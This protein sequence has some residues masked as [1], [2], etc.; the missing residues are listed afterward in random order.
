MKAKKILAALISAVMAVQSIPMQVLARDIDESEIS[1][2]AV[3]Q[4][5]ESVE[6][7]V[8]KQITTEESELSEIQEEFRLVREIDENGIQYEYVVSEINRSESISYSLKNNNL[9]NREVIIEIYTAEDL[10]NI[11]LDMSGHYMLMND[12]DMRYYGNWIPLGNQ[13]D[14]FMGTL[15]GNGYSIKN[16]TI[17]GDEY[18]FGTESEMFTNIGLF[19]CSSYSKIEN[20]TLENLNVDVSVTNNVTVGGF[21]G[22]CYNG[23]Q[24]E[25]CYVSGKISAYSQD[26]CVYAGGIVGYFSAASSDGSAY[27][28]ECGNSA[29]II[30]KQEESN[31]AIEAGGIVGII[32]DYSTITSCWN[33]GN[34]SAYSNQKGDAGGIVGSVSGSGFIVDCCTNIGAVVGYSSAGGIAG[35]ISCN[36][37]VIPEELYGVIVEICNSSNKGNIESYKSSGG[38]IGIARAPK[39]YGFL[40][41]DSFNSGTITFRNSTCRYVYGG[42]ILGRAQYYGDS[43]YYISD[44]YNTGSIISKIRFDNNESGRSRLG[45]IFGSIDAIEYVMCMN[46]YNAGSITSTDPISSGGIAGRAVLASEN[47][48]EAVQLLRS[49]YFLAQENLPIVGYS[50]PY[51]AEQCSVLDSTQMEDSLSFAGFDFDTVWEIGVTVGYPYPTLLDNPVYSPDV[52]VW[53]KNV[54]YVVLEEVSPEELG[55]LYGENYPTDLWPDVTSGKLL[56]GTIVAGYNGESHCWENGMNNAAMAFDGD[57]ETFFDPFDANTQSWCGMLL[58]KPYHL[59]E[60][61]ILPRQEWEDRTAGAAIQ[62]SNDGYLWK[63]IVYITDVNL[64]PAGRNYHCI[65]PESNE[66]YIEKYANLGYENMDL[67]TYWAG[68]GAYRYYRYV[69]ME[70]IHGDVAEI[71]LYGVP[72]SAITTTWDT[73]DL[74]LTEGETYAFSGKIKSSSPLDTLHIAVVRADNTS[75]GIDY[76]YAE[77][78]SSTLFDLSTIPSMAAGALL[79]GLQISNNQGQL[80]FGSGSYLIRMWIAD[81][82]G[83]YLNGLTKRITVTDVSDTPV[84]EMLPITEIT[85][86]TAKLQ[87]QIVDARGG[88]IVDF[89][90][91]MYDT[92]TGGERH[93]QYRA[94]QTDPKYQIDPYYQ[95]AEYDPE[96]GIFTVILRDHN[97]NRTYYAEGFAVYYQGDTPVTGFTPERTGFTTAVAQVNITSPEAY[98]VLSSADVSVTGN[99]DCRV[100][101]ITFDNPILTVYDYQMTEVASA[102]VILNND[103]T[104][105]AEIDLTEHYAGTYSI[106]VSADASNDSSV[107]S[108]PVLFNIPGK[109]AVYTDPVDESKITATK[110][111]VT[112]RVPDTMGETLKYYGFRTYDEAGNPLGSYFVGHDDETHWT[113]SFDPAT[114]VITGTI[115]AE[116]DTTIYYEAFASYKIG[117]VQI[118][119]IAATRESFTTKCVDITLDKINSY[120]GQSYMLDE[121]AGKIK[122]SGHISDVAAGHTVD[123]PVVIIRD[124]KG[125]VVDSVEAVLTGKNF[126]VE[127]NMVGYAPGIYTITAEIVADSVVA[128]YS[129]RGVSGRTSTSNEKEVVVPTKASSIVFKTNLGGEVLDQNTVH[130]IAHWNWLV[131]DLEMDTKRSNVKRIEWVTSDSSGLRLSMWNKSNKSFDQDRPQ[132]CQFNASKIGSYTVTAN[133]YNYDGTVTSASLSVEVRA[134]AT[135]CF[136]D[137]L[138]QTP[139]AGVNVQIT[140]NGNKPY[141][142]SVSSD[143]AGQVMLYDVPYGKFTIKASAKGYNDLNIVRTFGDNSN[144][145]VFMY[146]DDHV[147]Y[148]AE[149]TAVYT[150]EGEAVTTHSNADILNTSASLDKGK[151]YTVSIDVVADASLDISCYQLIQKEKVIAESND[152]NSPIVLYSLDS[153]AA[154]TPSSIRVCYKNGSSKDEP[155]QLQFTKSS[156]DDLKDES[157]NASFSIGDGISVTLPDNIPLL[158]GQELKLDLGKLP[159]SF[160]IQK[161][162][163]YIVIGAEDLFKDVSDKHNDD[164]TLEMEQLGLDE[165]VTGAINDIKSAISQNKDDLK[166]AIKTL[167]KNLTNF[168]EKTL[169]ENKS[170]AFGAEIV[171]VVLGTFIYDFSTNKGELEVVLKMKAE[172]EKNFQFFPAGIPILVTIKFGG[173]MGVEISVKENEITGTDSADTFLEIAAKSFYPT[174]ELSFTAD[175]GLGIAEIASLTAQGTSTFDAQI[176]ASP[177]FH[178]GLGLNIRLMVLIWEHIANLAG[179]EWM[180]KNG[181]WYQKTLNTDWEH[182]GADSAA[183][184]SAQSVYS[185]PTSQYSLADRSYL[186]YTSDWYEYN[187]IATFA[188][189]GDR[190]YTTDTDTLMTYIYP[191]TQIQTV[192]TEDHKVMIWLTDDATRS[193]A[194]RTKLV[195]SVYDELT[196]KWTTPQ[197]VADDGTLDSYP[198]LATDGTSIWA[199]WVNMNTALTDDMG[200]DTG[201]LHSEICAAMFDPQTMS[202]RQVT[203]LTAN[204]VIDLNPKLAVSGDTVAAAWVSNDSGNLW[205]TSGTNTIYISMYENGS[206][207]DAQAVKVLN[208]AVPA[209]EI[210]FVDGT[211]SVAY[212][213]DQDNSF[214]TVDDIAV[215]ASVPGTSEEYLLAEG[216]LNSNLQFVTIEGKQ[217]LTWYSDGYVRS[218]STFGNE[219]RD[220]LNGAAVTGGYRIVSDVNGTVLLKTVP[221]DGYSELYVS[222]YDEDDDSWSNDIRLTY[223]N[224]A[225]INDFG[226]MV[227]ENGDITVIYTAEIDDMAQMCSG[228]IGFV[229]DISLDSVSH[230][231]SDAVPGKM[232]KLYADLTN[233]GI[234]DVESVIFRMKQNDEVLCETAVPLL[235][236]A[237]E[238]VSVEVPVTVPETSGITEYEVEVVL[239]DAEEIDLSNNTGTVEFGH[240]N[241]SLYVSDMYG[242]NSRLLTFE[243]INNGGY[244]TVPQIVIYKDN[245]EKTVIDTLDLDVLSGKSSS[246]VNY[247]LT[248]L[249]D[250]VYIELISDREEFYTGDNVV[251]Y[252]LES[253]SPEI[254]YGDANGDGSVTEADNALLKQYFAGYNVS[255]DTAAADVDNDRVLTRRDAMILARHLAGWEGYTLPYLGE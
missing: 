81:T 66:V 156:L 69:N 135:L 67:S 215:H 73:S 145:V 79:K 236:K 208:R 167:D 153:C 25:N 49:C 127:C 119:S 84:I 191:D 83:N 175:G 92:E 242:E 128:A 189:F 45:G 169:E 114:G 235:M 164:Y 131:V 82:A 5:M 91:N 110:A 28:N 51:T 149:M 238:T 54:S 255:V 88:I 162:K 68:D 214:E 171:P 120:D 252:S 115:P 158:G 204:D 249:E 13:I 2:E 17:M 93:A 39:N 247:T 179:I 250:S 198:Y 9:Q 117:D 41:I 152:G 125:N 7:V 77:Q 58:D 151:N 213:L 218:I 217:F 62:G 207:S 86:S 20:L 197:S 251:Y 168:K 76:H 232:T 174:V 186:D 194:N 142:A 190:D 89:G 248:D 21:F 19:A 161:N 227:E 36:S 95:T 241:L 16:L 192:Q 139:I 59:T 101:G 30:V 72:E 211:L 42:G 85:A 106:I 220:M 55:N 50:D 122:F 71:E 216:G 210:G 8:I 228:T 147:V 136:V 124:S 14:H 163:L 146:D 11:S 148:S 132:T 18:T 202:F 150:S 4:T 183:Y 63:N 165:K 253:D 222:V 107:V 187:D 32:M 144:P 141:S 138:T 31:F 29:E 229:K 234:A 15:D 231:T 203:A 180:Y 129:A 109:L 137:F 254:V 245:E 155:V 6:D 226:A 113:T 118:D 37:S 246:V 188:S 26:N 3:E 57:P 176:K 78:I 233:H 206:W 108:A 97:P 181:E 12:I 102:D 56:K 65:T 104:F 172:G 96:T 178:L 116:P 111:I 60:I 33:V 140:S 212:C 98:Q 243:V 48:S 154:N 74:T 130:T 100:D 196:G 177:Y 230:N 105:S 166:G 173:S 239:P 133:V 35:T 10:A 90:F 75:V 123:M 159:A 160:T 27:I 193:S 61:R 200:L 209:M 185:V 199:A 219:P 40:I 94:K 22:A 195:Y 134:V 47:G 38:L 87:A 126:T 1:V 53:E 112:G 70:G 46:C 52:P 157:G 221:M 44:C 121:T 99:I 225:Y 240:G 182:M 143:S 223:Q 23:V 103:N 170:K 205:G 43:R 64:A 201:M 237:G 244:E 80:S 34:I 184:S 224:S 24:I